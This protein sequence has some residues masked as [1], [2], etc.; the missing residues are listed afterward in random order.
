[1][2][3]R[4]LSEVSIREAI[5]EHTDCLPSRNDRWKVIREHGPRSFTVVIVAI[6]YNA[7]I[8]FQVTVITALWTK[9]RPK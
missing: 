2:E 6:D 3:E 7:G 4:G 1:M 8:P 5:E 9:R